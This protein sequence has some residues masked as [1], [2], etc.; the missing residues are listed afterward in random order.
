MRKILI[1]L[2]I[3]CFSSILLVPQAQDTQPTPVAT[4][5]PIVPRIMVQASHIIVISM[6]GARPD[7]ILQVDSPVLQSLAAGGAATWQAQ[8]VL[9]AVTVPAHASMLTGLEVAEHGLDNNNYNNEAL[10][11]PTFISLAAERGYLTAMIVGKNKLDQFHYPE[12][13]AFT[14]AT[15]GDSSVIDAAIDALDDGVQVLFVHLPN[16]DYFG[17]LSG[18]M[19]P[20]YLAE[21]PNTDA[22]IG[23]LLAALEERQILDSTLLIITADHGGHDRKHGGDIPEDRLIPMIINGFGVQA[24]VELENISVTQVAAT[25]LYALQMPIPDEMAEPIREAFVP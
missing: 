8:T 17:H 15:S 22:Q 19:S 16:P 3:L 4:N 1:V 9:P 7:A 23:R 24:G 6:D 10:G 11:L 5:T 20:Q 2:L 25:V 13:V 18:W 21:L 14:F 12:N